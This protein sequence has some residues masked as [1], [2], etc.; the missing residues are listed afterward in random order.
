MADPL[1]TFDRAG[2]EA[3]ARD[4]RRLL[5]QV[6]NLGSR[7]R[8]GALPSSPVGMYLARTPA[9]GLPGRSGDEPGEATCDIFALRGGELKSIGT[10]QTV[11]NAFDGI[12]GSTFISVLRDPWGIWWPVKSPAARPPAYFFDPI[13]IRPNDPTTPFNEREVRANQTVGVFWE[14]YTGDLTASGIDYLWSSPVT[15][16]ALEWDEPT[17][18]F[19]APGTWRFDLWY[20]CIPNNWSHWFDS[21]TSA[22]TGTTSSHTHTYDQRDA[23]AVE[24]RLQLQFRDAGETAWVTSHG[25]SAVVDGRLGQNVSSPSGASTPSVH[26]L[27]V[28]PENAECRITGSVTGNTQV[29]EGWILIQAGVTWQHVGDLPTTEDWGLDVATGASPLPLR[30][31][32]KKYP[33][34]V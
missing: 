28:V 3:L 16:P 8:S 2:M 12:G 30:G 27:I 1:Y 4:H 6:Q 19:L 29:N 31:D 23:R 26:G 25:A 21:K 11:R 9:G 32:H 17:F 24:A 34:D 22:N 13:V 5:H 7:L 10:D 18:R 14:E 33:S 20:T 15:D